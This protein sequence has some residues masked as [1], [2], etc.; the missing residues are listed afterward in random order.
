M[1][2]RALRGRRVGNWAKRGVLQRSRR[3]GE[4]RGTGED[5]RNSSVQVPISLRRH[6]PDLVPGVE[7]NRLLSANGVRLPQHCLYHCYHFVTSMSK[8]ALYR[9]SAPIGMMECWNPGMMGLDYQLM[10]PALR[11]LCPI[12]WRGEKTL[13]YRANN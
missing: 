5:G 2:A 8:K 4:Y 11:P 13:K 6:Y 12:G 1:P 3:Y 10:E 9:C 7:A